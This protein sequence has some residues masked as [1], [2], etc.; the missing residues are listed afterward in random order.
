MK[1]TKIIATIGPASGDVDTLKVMMK[2]G[3][4]VARLNFSHGTDT[5]H[6]KLIANIRSA[7][8]KLDL[9]IPIIQDLSGPKLRLGECKEKSL[10]PGEHVVLGQHGVPVARHIWEWVKVGQVI[11]IDDGLIELVVIKVNPD[12]LET[13]VIQ[14]GTVI[15]HKGLSLPGVNVSLPSLSEKDLA[16][17]EFGIK[18]GVDFIALSFVKTAKDIKSLK[19][20][21]QKSIRKDIPVI[22][23][24]ETPEAIKNIDEVIEASD[25]VMVARGDLALNVDQEDV[26][27]FQKTIVHKCLEKSTPVIVATQMLDSMIKNSRPTRAEV[28]DVANAVIDHAD[29]VMLSGETAFGSYP[30]K[31][32]ETMSKIIEETEKSKYD[33]YHHSERRVTSTKDRQMILAHTI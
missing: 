10:K 4:N 21:I 27:L 24:I 8:G 29:A 17:L 18:S 20:I 1:R 22:S 7:A 15:S 11:L 12:S 5:S 25:A 31:T 33:N 3:M 32:V 9:H 28:S 13:K 30:L 23:K 16:D 6:A 14:G 2:A 26:P 19:K